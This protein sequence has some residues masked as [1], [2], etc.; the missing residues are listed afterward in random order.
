MVEADRMYAEQHT[1][2]AVL[3][4]GRAATVLQIYSTW[5][6]LYS[7]LQGLVR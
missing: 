1:L 2:A 6:R 7:S 3:V 5:C 4:S